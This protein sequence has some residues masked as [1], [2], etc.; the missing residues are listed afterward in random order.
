MNHEKLFI[1]SEKAAFSENM[2]TI[3]FTFELNLDTLK[4]NTDGAKNYRNY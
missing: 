2:V 3:E 4:I 1:G